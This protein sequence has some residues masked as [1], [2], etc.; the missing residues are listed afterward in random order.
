[1]TPSLPSARTSPATPNGNALDALLERSVAHER[2]GARLPRQL[3][4][5]GLAGAVIMTAVGLIGLAITHP[6]HMRHGGFLLVLASATVSLATLLHTL[7]VPF[8]CVGA[9][10]T[11][12]GITITFS[13]RRR[14]APPRYAVAAQ[15]LSGVTG[16]I[17][18]V[19]FAAL[20]LLNLIIWIVI[21]ITVL[22]I[23]GLAIGAALENA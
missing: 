6:A 1:M 4:L 8:I 17:V 23:I 12:I 21:F 22:M 19:P 9:V 10:L 3:A 11:L 20:L 16:A 5:Y 14:G 13:D 2:I 7:A 15:A 18:A